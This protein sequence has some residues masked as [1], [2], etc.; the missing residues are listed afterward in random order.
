MDPALANWLD[1]SK[2]SPCKKREPEYLPPTNAALVEK[3]ILEV[4]EEN[5]RREKVKAALEARRLAYLKRL[6]AKLKA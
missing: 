4:F 2:P 5:R 1:T 3:L 6:E